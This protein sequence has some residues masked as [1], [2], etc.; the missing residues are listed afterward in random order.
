MW[1]RLRVHW[2]Q[3][4]LGFADVGYGVGGGDVD[5][6]DGGVEEFGEG[7]GAMGGFGFDDWGAGGAMVPGLGHTAGFEGFGHPVDARCE[8]R[9]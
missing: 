2:E 6:E 3:A 1:T 9:R 7:E 8:G 4:S 5:D